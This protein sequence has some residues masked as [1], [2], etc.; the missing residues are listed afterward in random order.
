MVAWYNQ[1]SLTFRKTFQRDAL[2]IGT[3]LWIVDATSSNG[4]SLKNLLSAVVPKTVAEMTLP[5]MRKILFLE[6]SLARS[7]MSW[8]KV[9]LRL[10]P[11]SLV[12]DMIFFSRRAIG[13]LAF[14]FSWWRG[15][16]YITQWNRSK[17]IL[18]FIPSSLSWIMFPAT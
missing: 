4:S 8:C 16:R 5:N 14:L 6:F 17:K 1:N 12:A 18:S 11:S 13:S 7:V 15:H 3:T 9:L 10:T 2:G